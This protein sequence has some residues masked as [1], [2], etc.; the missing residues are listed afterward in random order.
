MSDMLIL[1]DGASLAGLGM[2]FVFVFLA[3]LVTSIKLMSVLTSYIKSV[4][5]PNEPARSVNQKNAVRDIEFMV[6][7]ASAIH[8]YRN[9]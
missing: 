8:R 5:E 9:P 6:V 1:S 2:G 7:I 3:I 4:P